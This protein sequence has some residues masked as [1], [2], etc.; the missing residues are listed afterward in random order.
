MLPALLLSIAL[1]PCAGHARPVTG[2]LAKDDPLPATIPLQVHTGPGADFAVA[3]SDPDNGA[4]VI[5]GY[6]RGGEFFRLLVP[7][8]V[9]DLTIVAGQPDDWQGL[10]GAFGADAAHVTLPLAFRI[11]DGSRR[12][13]HQITL[14]MQDGGLRI[15]DQQDQVICQIADWD[16]TQ[17]TFDRPGRVPLRYLDRSLTTRSRFCD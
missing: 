13:G 16:S 5:S 15:T 17:E 6:I 12:Q 3:L 9:H 10:Q 1:L 2:L 4:P 7:P 8:G 11:T 14:A